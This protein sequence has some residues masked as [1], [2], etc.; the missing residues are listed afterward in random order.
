[1]I[2]DHGNLSLCVTLSSLSLHLLALSFYAL[3]P[4]LL[5]F[6]ASCGGSD[7]IEAQLSSNHPYV[8]VTSDFLAY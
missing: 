4:A 3:F 8:E 1:M 7:K 5:C 2:E 6:K